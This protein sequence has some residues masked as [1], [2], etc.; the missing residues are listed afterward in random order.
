MATVVQ[1][2]TLATREGRATAQESTKSTMLQKQSNLFPM[3]IWQAASERC[4]LF[5]YRSNYFLGW[6]T[7]EVFSAPGGDCF[8]DWDTYEVFFVPGGGY[9]LYWDTNWEVFVPLRCEKSK[10][11]G[12]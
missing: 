2:K 6:G 1:E 3:I 7:F 4:R 9:F 12:D 5:L 8:L 10:I 11:F